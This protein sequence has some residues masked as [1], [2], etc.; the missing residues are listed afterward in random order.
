LRQQEFKRM[1][2]QLPQE[3]YDP[4]CKGTLWLLRQNHNDLAEHERVRLRRLFWHAP[5]LHQAYTFRAELTALCTQ[6]PTYAA[7]ERRLTQWIHKVE[8]STLDCYERFLKTL[9]THWHPIL[10]D[11]DDRVNR[12][13]VED[14]NNKIKTIKRRCY[15]IRK[16]ATLFQR[17]WLDLEALERFFLSTP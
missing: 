1:K 3:I 14:L 13:F 17:I 7:G 5:P 12:G 10:N 8:Q 2:K 15:G 9:R 4:D 6:V 16:I 11:F